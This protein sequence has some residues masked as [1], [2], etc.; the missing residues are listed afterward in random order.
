MRITFYPGDRVR[1]CESGHAFEG[2][3]GTVTN[4][5]PEINRADP[6]WNGHRGLH[7]TSSGPVDVY[8]VTF[9]TPQTDPFSEACDAAAIAWTH[10]ELVD[11]AAPD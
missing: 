4:A 6:E 1:V 5:P 10:L 8:W 11:S 3:V 7:P 9:D 2:A